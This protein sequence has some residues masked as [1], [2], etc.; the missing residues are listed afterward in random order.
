MALDPE[1]FTSAKSDGRDASLLQP[2][3]WNRIVALFESLLD[4]D[5]DDFAV[6]V[7]GVQALR[8]TPSLTG[9]MVVGDGGASMSHT[10][11]QTGFY[12]TLVGRGAGEDLTTA[13]MTTA[14]GYGALA[15]T[16]T[17]GENTAIGAFAAPALISGGDNVAIGE[18]A[19]W[20]TTT[21]Q[22]NIAIGVDALALSDTANNNVAIGH[23]AG[24]GVQPYTSADNVFI[25]DRVAAAVEG[26]VDSNVMIGSGAGSDFLSGSRNILIGTDT[27]SYA[28]FDQDNIVND[29]LN[30][31]NKY[32]GNLDTGR[33]GIGTFD[34]AFPSLLS[35]FEVQGNAV[36]GASYFATNAAPM[37]G[38]LVQ[39]RVGIGSTSPT[40]PLQIA[41]LT[42]YADNAAAVS[43]G[44]TA[45]AFYHT[46]GV[47]KVVT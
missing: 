13:G 18:E 22:E 40:S 45:G 10:S 16:T 46:S 43:G 33:F 34:S 44:L 6:H 9:S 42:N 37:N 23:N 32:F 35:T 11:A 3:Y 7:N 27:L 4:G 24:H 5:D 15:N 47:L 8:I 1:L 31:G 30:I 29:L 26:G 25:G 17:A 21:G 2:S 39:G 41:G 20:T 38:L 14:V 28:A 36:I 12:N 19:M